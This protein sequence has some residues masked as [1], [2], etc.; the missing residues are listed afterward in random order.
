[1]RFFKLLCLSVFISNFN[2]YGQEDNK[3]HPLLTDKFTF[4]AGVYSSTKDIK[5]KVNGNLPNSPINFNEALGLNNNE[6]T[7]FFN[8]N[9]KFAKRW[10]LSAEYFNV[11]NGNKLV[12]KEDIIWEDITFKEGS[13]VKTG[14]G[15]DMYRVV[16]SRIFSKGDHHELGIGLGAHILNVDAFIKGDAYINDEDFTFER[17]GVQVVAPLPNLAFWYYYAPTEKWAFIARIDWLGVSIGDYYGGLWNIGPGVQYQILKNVGLSL[18]YRYFNL[19]AKVNKKNWDG[20]FNM[21]FNGPMLSVT[22]NF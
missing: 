19:G 10:V 13:N 20:R 12:L 17:R 5:I 22:A 1:M 11:Q 3:K 16:V 18:N 15:L 7:P 4:N 14:F 6:I 9:W 21:I 2:I 8:F